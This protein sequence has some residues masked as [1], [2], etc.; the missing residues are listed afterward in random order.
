MVKIDTSVTEEWLKSNKNFIKQFK[1][2]DVY[3]AVESGLS[4]QFL[5]EHTF[6]FK[7][8]TYTDGKHPKIR[9]TALICCNMDGTDK[10]EMLVIE[11]SKKKHRASTKSHCLQNIIKKHK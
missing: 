1:I 8:K 2:S 9:I 3:N 11:K 10:R 4:N 5:P 7:G 6:E